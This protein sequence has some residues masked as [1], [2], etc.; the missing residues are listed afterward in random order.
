M[1]P[2]VVEYCILYGKHGTIAFNSE[3][4]IV[5]LFAR[6]RARKEGLRAALDPL[7]GHSQFPS[8]V[9]DHDLFGIHLILD[10]EPPTHV[11]G[12]DTDRVFPHTQA[13][14]NGCPDLV[15]GLG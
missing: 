3:F 7:D 9:A 13:A 8:N 14:G 1:R 6:V 12:F 5:H 4:G 10:A 2:R 11:P 15:G